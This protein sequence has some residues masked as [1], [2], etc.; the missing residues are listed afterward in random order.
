MIFGPA[1]WNGLRRY[2]RTFS[3]PDPKQE[4]KKGGDMNL[5]KE[6]FVMFVAIALGMTLLAGCQTIQ[7]NNTMSKE[8]MLETAGFQRKTA[9][10]PEQ[11][12]NVQSMLQRQVFSRMKDG[13][14]MYVY[15]DGVVCQCV[16]VGTED[17]F[18]QYMQISAQQQQAENQE[19][20]AEVNHEDFINE[21]AMMDW[22]VWGAWE[23][24]A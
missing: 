12:A 20:T 18:Q 22:D 1:K 5:I 23:P 4:N 13:Q 14:K 7:N 8:Q 3:R 6:R 11:L 9:Q 17:N 15:A 19:T 21:S 10:T 2:D 16:Y 24:W